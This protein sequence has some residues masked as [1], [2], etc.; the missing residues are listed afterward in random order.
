MC[1]SQLLLPSGAVT[2]LDHG[3][4]CKDR[5]LR[6]RLLETE[7]GADEDRVKAVSNDA[8]E[9]FHLEAVPRVAT[10]SPR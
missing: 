4:K 3:A 8:L 5:G 1:S 10:D 7:V 2:A 9:R 6:C